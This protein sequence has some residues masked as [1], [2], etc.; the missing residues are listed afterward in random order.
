MAETLHDAPPSEDSQRN[1][2]ALDA[3]A[4]LPEAPKKLADPAARPVAGPEAAP[5]RRH[6]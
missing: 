2:E 1:P 6:R 5:A 3:G 4:T